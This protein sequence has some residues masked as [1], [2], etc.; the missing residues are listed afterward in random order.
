[1]VDIKSLNRRCKQ[2]RWSLRSASIRNVVL[3]KQHQLTTSRRRQGLASLMRKHR[4]TFFYDTLLC[5]DE[6]FDAEPVEI[7]RRK[8]AH[9]IKYFSADIES[10]LQRLDLD[11]P[12]LSSADCWES[13]LDNPE[14]HTL[15]L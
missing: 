7:H 8:Q 14:V 11:L 4:S 12:D 5:A 6:S 13:F 1:V 2:L 9:Y 10:L 3:K 15:L